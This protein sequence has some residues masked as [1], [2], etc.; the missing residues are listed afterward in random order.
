MKKLITKLE[1]Y[2]TFHINGRGIVLAVKLLEGDFALCGDTI[3]FE[4]K[5]QL[6][7][8]KI[9]GT[10]YGM[11]VPEGKPNKG[12]LIESLNDNELNQL[13]DWNPVLIHAEIYRDDE[14]N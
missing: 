10:D 7:E 6:I 3:K 8:R 11:R 1:I 9:I 12:L 14:N 2:D 4:F 5:G 13:K